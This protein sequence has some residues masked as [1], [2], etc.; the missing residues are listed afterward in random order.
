M[1]HAGIKIPPPLINVT[2]L[3][4]GMG[5]EFLLPISNFPVNWVWFFRGAAIVL[6]LLGIGIIF[7]SGSKFVQAQTPVAPWKPTTA[8]VKTGPYGLSRNPFYF[9]YSIM[10]FALALAFASIYMVLLVI[11]AVVT[12]RWY[13]IAREERYLTEKFGEEYCTYKKHV[14]RWI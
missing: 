13:V 6:F 10:H 8:L 9:S 11:P 4:L 2:F 14:R 12:I 1:Q 5:M 7:L 3:L